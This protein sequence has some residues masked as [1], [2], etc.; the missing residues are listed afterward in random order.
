V[1]TRVVKSR[2]P[3]ELAGV[4]GEAGRMVWATESGVSGRAGTVAAKPVAAARSG[5]RSGRASEHDSEPDRECGP[6]VLHAI[7]TSP[8]TPG[9][10]PKR[11]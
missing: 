8:A 10:A 9:F 7:E 6:D 4:T 3:V 11:V 5:L 2:V 1:E